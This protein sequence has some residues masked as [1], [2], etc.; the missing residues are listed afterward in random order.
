MR[1]SKFGFCYPGYRYCGPWCSGPGKP[2][3]PVDNC[4]MAHDMCYASRKYHKKYCDEI[5]QNCLVNYMNPY[6]K[7]GKEAKLFSKLIHTKNFFF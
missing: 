5:F 1:S 4:C 3:N 7:M 6:T 2:I